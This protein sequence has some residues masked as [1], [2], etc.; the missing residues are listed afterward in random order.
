MAYATLILFVLFILF[1]Y[2]FI[3]GSARPGAGQDA[4]CR[5]PKT[6]PGPAK[7]VPLIPDRLRNTAAAAIMMA[8]NTLSL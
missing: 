3:S 5:W 2:L 8:P 4:V 7:A 6:R 1:I